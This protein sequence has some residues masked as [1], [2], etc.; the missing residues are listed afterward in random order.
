M[1]YDFSHSNFNFEDFIDA[2]TSCVTTSKDDISA[3]SLGIYEEIFSLLKS[4]FEEEELTTLYKELTKHR[5]N[6]GIPYAIVANEVHSLKNMLISSNKQNI[7]K[8]DIV[9]L[10]NLFESVNNSIASIYLLEYIKELVALNDI[11]IHSI[12]DLV[13]KNIMLHYEA[14]LIWLSD[15]AIHI[16]D[17]NKRDFPELN[18]T[19]CQFG[20]WLHNEAKDV[21]PNKKKV[22]KSCKTTQK[23]SSLCFKDIQNSWKG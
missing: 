13:E 20:L 9:A 11:R 4:S 1:E 17:K 3:T 21:I 6:N 16:E 18:H 23:P 14:H 8:I 12:E 15:L 10:L 22:P 7:H 19:L 5:L 2:Y